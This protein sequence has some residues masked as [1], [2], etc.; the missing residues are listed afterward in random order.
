MASRF[1]NNSALNA[2]A[3]AGAGEILGRN[4]ESTVTFVTGTTGTVD[5]HAL[6]TVTGTVA[7]TVIGVCSVN[8]ASA[9]GGTIKVGTALDTDGLILDTTATDIDA[10]EIWHDTTPDNSVESLDIL[11]KKVVN[12]SVSY[13]ITTGAIS[14]GVIKF[15]C[16]WVPISVNGNVVAA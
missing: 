4:V 11:A 14:A 3:S 10:G 13:V 2:L 8:L 15:I 16:L 12:Q 5:T 9:G 6:F 7:M 1:S